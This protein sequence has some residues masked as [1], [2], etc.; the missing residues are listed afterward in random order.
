MVRIGQDRVP[1]LFCPRW[2]R[3]LE[4]GYETEMRHSNASP[5]YTE[6]ETHLLS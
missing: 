1:L 3:A 2:E 4:G 6:W 5:L